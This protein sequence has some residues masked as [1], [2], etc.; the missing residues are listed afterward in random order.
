MNKLAIAVLVAGTAAV[1]G[2]VVSK[3]M[4][5]KKKPNTDFLDDYDDCCCE[6]GDSLDVVIPAEDDENC[7]EELSDAVEDA[8]EVVADKAEDVV[9]AVKDAID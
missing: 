3:M 5:N 6:C 1:T 2:V 4:K 9:D 7:A 8:A